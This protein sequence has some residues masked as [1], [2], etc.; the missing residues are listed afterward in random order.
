MIVAEPVN[1]GAFMMEID[2]AHCDVIVQRWEEFTG[3]QAEWIPA[4]APAGET[5]A[6]VVAGEVEAA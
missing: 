4:N 6:A 3:K 5:P 1:R 2:P